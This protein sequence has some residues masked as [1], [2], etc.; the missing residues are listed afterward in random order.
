MSPFSMKIHHPNEHSI[1]EIGFG[2]FGIRYIF[3]I[4]SGVVPNR[5][6]TGYEAVSLAPAS[7]SLKAYVR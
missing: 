7:R 5:G 3:G 6:S 1:V 4:G 2:P